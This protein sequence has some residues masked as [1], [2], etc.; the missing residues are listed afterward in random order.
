MFGLLKRPTYDLLIEPE[1]ITLANAKVRVEIEPRLTIAEGGR[2]VSVGG[3][4]QQMGRVVELLG[5]ARQ[6]E[7]PRFEERFLGFEAI[8]RHLLRAA[9]NSAMFALRPDVRV[10]GASLLR[11]V[12]IGGD[13]QLF[14]REALQGAGAVKVEFAG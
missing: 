10:R 2:I 13:E 1:R 4:A 3:R 11:G 12:G 8:F 9:Q 6:E 7:R 14:L 5:P